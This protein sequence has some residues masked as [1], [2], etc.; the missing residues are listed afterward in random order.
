M[1]KNM[2]LIL[3]VI[4]IGPSFVK[5]NNDNIYK[6]VSFAEKYYKTVYYSSNDYSTMSINPGLYFK[7]EEIS[8]EEYDHNVMV[9]A[10]SIETTYKKLTT[11]ILKSG[12]YY[13][14]KVVLSW[15]NFPKIRSYDII[16]I[17]FYPSVKIKGTTLFFTQEYCKKS[18]GCKTSTTHNPQKFSSGAGTSFKLPEGDLTSLTQTF[19]FNVDK[20]TDATIVKQSAAGD[21]AH[22]IKT[23]SISQAKNY[24][25]NSLG[26]SVVGT[27]AN[28]F[29]GIDSATAIWTGKW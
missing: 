28:N 16:G 29:D 17:G 15:K 27:N 24:T 8:K 19:Y 23:V 10:A 4:L 12:D 25:V 26:I 7:T 5:A 1:K 14:Y 2:F 21:Y 6:V 20:N 3:I 22:A 13:R 11:Y 9:N 18:E